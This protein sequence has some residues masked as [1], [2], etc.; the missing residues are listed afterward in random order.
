M[1]LIWRAEATGADSRAFGDTPQNGVFMNILLTSAGRR[2]YLVEFFKQALDGNGL[3]HAGNSSPVSPAFYY[4]D[5][6]VVTPL[7]YDSGYIPF[8]KE[9]C[10]ANDIK[11]VV[12]L[13][14]VDLMV[15]AKHKEEFAEMG[16]TVVVSDPD[17]IDIC[18][19]KW[20]T[21]EFCV[22]NQFNAPKT[23]K[24]LSD[25]KAALNDG[26][27]SYPVMV[28]P[29][30]GMG[31]IA[32]CQADNEKELEVFAHKVR[33]E[34]FKS[35]L[36]YESEPDR[37]F[38][39]LFQE[40]LSGQE[41]GLDVIHDLNKKHRLT[42]VRKKIAM[43]SGETDCAAVVKDPVAEELGTS[44]GRALGHIGNLDM[45]VFVTEDGNPYVLEL[46]ARFGGGYPFSHFAGVNLPKAL[47]KW[48][49]GDECVDELVIKEYD[50]LAQKDI[51][52]ID[53]TGF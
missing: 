18:N 7:I 29:R 22:K 16:V 6:H 3:V 15:L 8:L 12:S 24:S 20:K 4:A 13:F 2:G 27:L 49:A 26:A 35:Y 34:I 52:L 1:F 40:K 50:R 46:N 28:K 14:D 32:V 45:D 53:I 33:N 10:K 39:V 25:V 30:W 47:L 51:R 44:L 19:D 37:D 17:V 43:R 41:Y 9:Y 36:K 21:Y 31:S 5:K 11:A 48:I 42:V 23:Y 38:C